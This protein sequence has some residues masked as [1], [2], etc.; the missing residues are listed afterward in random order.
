MFYFASTLILTFTSL[1]L[2]CFCHNLNSQHVAMAAK[3]LLKRY[4]FGGECLWEISSSINTATTVNV[5][6]VN[7]VPQI[8]HCTT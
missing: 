1:P 5:V 6:D 7:P 3:I 4:Y 8:C 2:I